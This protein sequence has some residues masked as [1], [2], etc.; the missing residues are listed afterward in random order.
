MTN[1][2]F[3]RIRREVLHSAQAFRFRHN[4]KSM[5]QQLYQTP[6]TDYVSVMISKRQSDL[7]VAK[8]ATNDWNHVESIKC[9][10][11]LY[12]EIYMNFVLVAM[13]FFPQ[14]ESS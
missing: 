10:R 9:V 1:P 14:T 13:F 11:I 3:R 4:Q 8:E 5:S 6:I 12:C 7:P 2:C